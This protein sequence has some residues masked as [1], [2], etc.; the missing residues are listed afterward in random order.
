MASLQVSYSH[1]MQG[2]ISKQYIDE[3]I[4]STCL[5]TTLKVWAACIKD[6]KKNYNGGLHLSDGNNSLSVFYDSYSEWEN[7]IITIRMQDRRGNH[8]A[9]R[10]MSLAKCRRLV[11][12]NVKEYFESPANGICEVIKN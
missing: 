12:K 9:D 3:S 6:L 10:K 4:E 5:E 7:D 2:I 8:G 1:E 11:R